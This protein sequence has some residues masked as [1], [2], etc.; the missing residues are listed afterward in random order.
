M[1]RAQL[2]PATPTN[3]QYAFSFA[4]LDW[5]EALL[6][7]CQVSLKDFCSALT[8]RAHFHTEKNRNFYPRMINAF[9]EFRFMKHSLRNLCYITSKL[10]S[11]NICPA[12]PQNGGV[13]VYAM[14]ALFGLPRKKSAGVSYK[15]PL[16]GSLFFGDQSAVDQFVAESSK[17]KPKS[18]V[19]F[20]C[21]VKYFT[22]HVIGM[23]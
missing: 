11:G 14:D 5:A 7:E 3:P 9:E 16:L 21:F 13:K 4:L 10:D 15:E 17:T 18:S 1:C 22:L 23:Q 20:R 2:W 6:L 8:F 12:C 19:S